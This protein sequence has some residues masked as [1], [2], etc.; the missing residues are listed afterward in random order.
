MAFFSGNYHLWFL[1]VI[2]ELYLKAFIK[3]SFIFTFIIPN[4]YECISYFPQI[5]SRIMT[6]IKKNWISNILKDTFFIS[7]LDI[8]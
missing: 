8:I 5:L 2:I 1:D 6:I 3:P 7:C 4:I